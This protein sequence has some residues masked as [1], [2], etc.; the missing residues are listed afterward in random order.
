MVKTK[1]KPP[2]PD[3]PQIEQPS[4]PETDPAE[5]IIKWIAARR[6]LFTGGATALVV[7]LGVVW[8]F[9]SADARRETFAANALD[10]AR[11]AVQSGNAALAASDLGRIVAEYGR[12]RAGQ[13]A[14]ILLARTRLMNGQAEL[15][16]SE[17]RTFLS[18]GPR[19]QFVSQG[20]GLLATALEQ[21]GRFDEASQ[22]F[23]SAAAA[24]DHDLISAQYLLEAGRTAMQ[25]N[26]ADRA[27]AMYQRV[28]DEHAEEGIAQEARL[29]LG[30]AE[31]AGR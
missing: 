14:V 29:R 7:L 17:L 1:R 15:A 25:A 12:T 23:E 3:A 2:A 31:A 26:D 21:L 4:A 11:V 10:N 27:A 16:V 6:N 22:A 19:D 9:R 24:A 30:E 28:V 20:Q 13:E 18:G 8:F 5:R